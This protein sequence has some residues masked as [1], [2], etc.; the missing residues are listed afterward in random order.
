DWAD[1]CK[2]Q[3]RTSVVVLITRKI[4]RKM[5]NP[6][7]RISVRSCAMLVCVMYLRS[8]GP[9][10][11]D[12]DFVWWFR[13]ARKPTMLSPARLKLSVHIWT[14]MGGHAHQFGIFRTSRDQGKLSFRFKAWCQI[15]RRK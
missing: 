4:I 12:G 14:K 3:R 10:A 5:M 7:S 9:Q 11:G 13:T 1:R 2:I 6:A 15:F 8:L